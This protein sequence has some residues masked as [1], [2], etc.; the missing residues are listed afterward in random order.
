MHSENGTWDG[1]VTARW[2]VHWLQNHTIHLPSQGR[3]KE[4][5][6]QNREELWHN[7][8]GFCFCPMMRSFNIFSAATMKRP[9]NY[10]LS[11]A[12]WSSWNNKIYRFDCCLLIFMQLAVAVFYHQLTFVHTAICQL[13]FFSLREWKGGREI[14][15]YHFPSIS[16]PLGSPCLVKLKYKRN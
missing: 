3:R 13:P 6:K 11:T 1:G 9:V 12:L 16:V 7:K 5:E 2:T 14:E 15:G 8:Y 4:K 10:L